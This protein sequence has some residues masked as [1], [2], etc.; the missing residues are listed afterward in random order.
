MPEYNQRDAKYDEGHRSQD[1][2]TSLFGFCP[3]LFAPFLPFSFPGVPLAYFL[4]NLFEGN[5]ALGGFHLCGFAF[6]LLALPNPI[7][8]TP[9]SELLSLDAKARVVSLRLGYRRAM[10]N[11]KHKQRKAK[12]R[13]TRFVNLLPK[14]AISRSIFLSNLPTYRNSRVV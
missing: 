1:C 12:A 3:F 11:N 8:D 2:N 5:T 13:Q 7:G 4:Q 14:I 10:K 9:I 6:G